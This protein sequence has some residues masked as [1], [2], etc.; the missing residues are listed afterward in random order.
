MVKIPLRCVL[1]LRIQNVKTS[2]VPVYDSIKIVEI[3]GAEDV[4]GNERARKRRTSTN[5]VEIF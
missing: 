3:E 1:V 4:S 2:Q 5:F